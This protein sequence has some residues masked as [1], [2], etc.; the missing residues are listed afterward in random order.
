MQQSWNAHYLP[1]KT[2]SIQEFEK[3]KEKK[4]KK[5]AT[6]YQRGWKNFERVRTK[7]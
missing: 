2:Q 5:L 4:K 1:K 7:T 6:V 3:K